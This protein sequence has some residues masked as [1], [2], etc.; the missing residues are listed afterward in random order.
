MSPLAERQNAHV[1]ENRRAVAMAANDDARRPVAVQALM[2]SCALPPPAEMVLL[3]LEA[4][5]TYVA[6]HWFFAT[7]QP[8]D[9]C[10]RLLQSGLEWWGLDDLGNDYRGF[11]LGGGGGSSGHWTATTWFAPALATGVGTIKLR[12]TSPVDRTDV[13]AELRLDRWTAGT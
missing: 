2:V 13:V 8:S 7:A 9:A 5:T 10:D 6:L 1:E 11:D 3:S 12:F 4:W